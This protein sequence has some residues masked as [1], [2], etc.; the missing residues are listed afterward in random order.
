MLNRG[1]VRPRISDHHDC[2]LVSLSDRL[3][4]IDAQ[5]IDTDLQVH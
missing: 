3:H 1:E 2:I 4:P 5:R